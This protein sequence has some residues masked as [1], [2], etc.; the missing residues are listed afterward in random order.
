M[1][2]DRN[3]S[4]IVPCRDVAAAKRFYTGTLGLPLAED[5][6][7]VFAVRT[8]GTRLNVYKSD[9]AGTNKANAVV[10]DAGSEVEA[11]AADLRAKGVTLDEYPEGFDEVRQGVH[12]KGDFRAIWFT[13]PDGNILHVNGV[14]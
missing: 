12:V 4:A 14:A 2:A 13:D 1:L 6:G 5:H 10:W 3:S 11:I 9:Y 7:A 8:G